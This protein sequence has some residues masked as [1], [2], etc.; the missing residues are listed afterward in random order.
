[1]TVCVAI[2]D[3][4]WRLHDGLPRQA[5]GS[6]ATTRALLRL[7]RQLP[8][9]PRTLDI[10]SGPGRATLVLAGDADAQVTAVDT[11]EPFLGELRA[12]AAAAGLADRVATMTTPMEQLDLPD[13]SV[14][15][16]WAEGSV[17]LM[18]FDAALRAWRR[19]LSPGGALVLTEAEWLTETPSDAAR[20]FWSEAYPAMRT[21]ADN[22][23]AAMSAGWTVGAV[24]VLPESD[25]WD[26]YYTVLEDRLATLDR[27]DPDQAAVHDLESREIMMRRA[28]GADYAYTG[29]VLRP[30]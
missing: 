7:A 2:E 24:Y 1:M 3:V 20:A 26:E 15:L 14:D 9:Q 13:G 21:T 8:P 6:D 17:Y 12:A 5:P 30:R 25:W 4:F 29:Y 10:G 18:G 22:V 11:H 16:I 28:H 27:S 23:A 19:L